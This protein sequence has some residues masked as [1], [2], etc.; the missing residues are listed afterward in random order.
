MPLDQLTMVTF[1]AS[2]EAPA[3]R[4]LWEELG[5][6]A[7]VVARTSHEF[8][9]ALRD[10]NPSEGVVIMTHGGQ[11]ALQFTDENGHRLSYERVPELNCRVVYGF[12]CNQRAESPLRGPVDALLCTGTAYNA[13]L[14][15]LMFSIASARDPF[16]VREVLAARPEIP[17]TWAVHPGAASS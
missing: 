17:D 16:D 13:D 5:G 3:L 14:V 8:I 12:T 7:P 11:H 15:S 9:A 4:R 1:D 10:V 6:R 2:S